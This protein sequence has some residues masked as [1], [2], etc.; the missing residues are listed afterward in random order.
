MFTFSKDDLF[1]ALIKVHVD[2]MTFRGALQ[3]MVVRILTDKE[4][5]GATKKLKDMRNGWVAMNERIR[6]RR[7]PIRT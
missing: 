5:D 4:V 2:D 6:T 3:T 7:A 1:E